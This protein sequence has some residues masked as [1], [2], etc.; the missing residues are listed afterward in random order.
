MTSRWL[1]IATLGVF[2]FLL[3]A[4]ALAAF[5]AAEPS[6]THAW[7]ADGSPCP[8][9]DDQHGPCDDGCACHCCHSRVLALW[10][11][12][13]ELTGTLSPPFAL[14]RFG[15]P[16]ELQPSGTLD[17]VFRPPRG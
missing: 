15:V 3:V 13:P 5:G 12:P 9:Q 7:H 14:P 2:A 1:A 6:A 11:A 10:F 16:A 17:R 4:P 8:D